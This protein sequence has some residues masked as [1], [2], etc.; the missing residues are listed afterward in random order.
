MVSIQGQDHHVTELCPHNWL[1]TFCSHTVSWHTLIG[2]VACANAP[3]TS[4][5]SLCIY[6]F[7]SFI[8]HPSTYAFII[9]PTATSIIH[10]RV[11][12]LLTTVNSSVLYYHSLMNPVILPLFYLFC[13]SS[14]NIITRPPIYLISN[15]FIHPSIHL[16]TCLPI[17]PS[18]KL[19]I[20]PTTFLFLS[21]INT[22]WSTYCIKLA[23]DK[24]I[25]NR[26]TDRH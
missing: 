26:K 11:L 4:I 1:I 24:T 20:Y 13:D 3:D 12:L 18:I 14:I 2:S 22:L 23:S 9:G 8:L 17:L 25:L 6:S 16:A 19:F 21:F 5:H 15:T 7:T 10:P